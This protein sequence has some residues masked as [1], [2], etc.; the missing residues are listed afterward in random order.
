M[1]HSILP[2]DDTKR[3]N[4]DS[5]GN[6]SLLPT[7]KPYLL[8]LCAHSYRDSQGRHYVDLL[9]YKDL[10]EHLKYREQLILACPCRQEEPVE[11]MICLDD[12]P[13]FAKKV[14]YVDLPALKSFAEALLKLPE[15]IG[16][17]WQAVGQA[18]IVESCVAGWPIAPGWLI[19][20][21]VLV[22]RKFYL[23][24][25]ESSFWR[26]S[27]GVKISLI[28][29]I[30][31]NFSELLNRW[32][33]NKT[34][35]AIFA[36]EEWRRT[37]LTNKKV[38]SA[39]IHCS[40]ISQDNLISQKDAQALWQT[41]V[42]ANIQELNLIFAGRL[43]EAKGIRVLLKAAEILNTKNVHVKLDI[44]GDG[45]FLAECIEASQCIQGSVKINMLGT[46]P[47]GPQLFDLLREYHA[48]VLPSLTDEQMRIVYDAY[49]QSLPVLASKANG[50]RDCVQDGETGVFYDVNNPA[51]L[52][53]TCTWAL[54]NLNQLQE[55]GMNSLQVAKELTHQEMHRQRFKLLAEMLQSA[56]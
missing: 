29:R 18:E 53:E 42:S 36:Q 25:V 40:W 12:D 17:Y 46:V 54:N 35:L 52:A 48:I 32:C 41:K 1:A 4:Q 38:K 14:Q 37:L 43:E 15:I 31:A 34:D 24:V 27:P 2:S 3:K 7:S 8:A 28:R 10:A 20:P 5:H 16:K 30:R 9:W 23:I 50:L 44:L 45:S 6:F 11:G 49:S 51:A 26:L 19:T 22:R 55:M 33:L 21:M 39:V 47:Y 13:E 56:S